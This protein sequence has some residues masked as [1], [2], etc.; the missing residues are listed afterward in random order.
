VLPFPQ[1]VLD[2]I[3]KYCDGCKSCNQDNKITTTPIIKCSVC[4]DKFCVECCYSF[5]DKTRC[6]NCV[7]EQEEEFNEFVDNED[8]WKIYRIGFYQSDG[9]YSKK[10]KMYHIE[11]NDDNDWILYIE[12]SDGERLKI[13]SKGIYGLPHPECDGDTLIFYTNPDGETNWDK[14]KQIEQ[15]ELEDDDT[16]LTDFV[17]LIYMLL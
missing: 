2:K 15:D 14:F 3:H 12:D 9:L 16:D 1:L 13:G 8:N 4:G 17:E 11:Y 7:Y 5:V 10:Y 6:D